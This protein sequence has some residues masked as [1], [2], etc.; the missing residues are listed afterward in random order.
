MNWLL[1]EYDEN[2][3]LS[4]LQINLPINFPIDNKNVE[5]EYQTNHSIPA[6]YIKVIDYP[7]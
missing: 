7:I 4:V 3:D 6:K 5:W 1:D 2:V